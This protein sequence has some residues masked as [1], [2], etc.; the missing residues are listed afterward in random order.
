MKFNNFEKIKS[1]V[2]KI[3]PITVA[4]VSLANLSEGQSINRQQTEN[5]SE[6]NINTQESDGV[7]L[8]KI[9]TYEKQ[10]ESFADGKNENDN[11]KSFTIVARSDIENAVMPFS[12][13]FNDKFICE[14][15]SI[16]ISQNFNN[17]QM[18]SRNSSVRTAFESE[19]RLAD[20]GFSKGTHFT[21]SKPAYY[22]VVEQNELNNTTQFVLK[23]ISLNNKKIEI[24]ASINTD[25][26]INTTEKEKEFSNNVISLLRNK[27]QEK[28]QQLGLANQ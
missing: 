10:W 12:S 28:I 6:I 7:F 2:K 1:E 8:N 20:E 13:S 26:N 5:S 16:D 3:I 23:C 18:I 19:K 27:V 17:P 21:Y 25:T 15:I 14:D 11:P 24:L 4:A 9:N 22:F